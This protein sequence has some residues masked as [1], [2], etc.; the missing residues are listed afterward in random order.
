M[1]FD[2]RTRAWWLRVAGNDCQARFY[3]EEKGIQQC[4]NQAKELHHIIPESELI[5]QGLNPNETTGLPLC[6]QHHRGN[7]DSPMFSP[8]QSFHPDM[9]QALE[10]YR[11]GDKDAFKRASQ[12]HIIMAQNGERVCNGDWTTDE[13]YAQGMQGLANRYLQS[14]PD[15]P[16]PEAKVHKKQTK[17][18]RWFDIF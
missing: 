10:L 5:I 4:Q 8:D 18:K 6:T 7:S 14:H 13:Y 12:E 11:Q 16:K 15:D 17:P 3:T 9:G 1:P 2:E